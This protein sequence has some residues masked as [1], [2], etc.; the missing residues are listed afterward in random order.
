MM[1]CPAKGT[2]DP[3]IIW[4]FDGDEIDP[5]NP[6]VDGL[7]VMPGNI[8]RINRADVDHSGRYTCMARNKVGMDEADVTVYIMSAFVCKSTR[9]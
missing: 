1:S 9:H 2:P 8:I 7:A 4:Y 6:H 3:T 5:N